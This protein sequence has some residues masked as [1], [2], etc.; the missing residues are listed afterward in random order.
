M[1]DMEVL[2]QIEEVTEPETEQFTQQEQEQEPI[3]TTT[4]QEREQETT[5][6]TTSLTDVSEGFPDQAENIV[7]Q[8]FSEFGVNLDYVPANKNQAFT[9]GCQLITAG[10]FFW[11]FIKIIVLSIRNF[12][13]W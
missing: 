5:T 8:L 3:E 6:T 4:E 2:E 13:K 9:M 10:L 12:L 7:H 1:D 11:C